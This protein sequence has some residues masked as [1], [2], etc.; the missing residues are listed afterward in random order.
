[1]LQNIFFMQDLFMTEGMASERFKPYQFLL[2]REGITHAEFA[3]RNQG[4]TVTQYLFRN[5]LVEKC[6]AWLKVCPQFFELE[7]KQLRIFL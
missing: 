2:Q 3:K 4:T 7:A 5:G 6:L 1:M